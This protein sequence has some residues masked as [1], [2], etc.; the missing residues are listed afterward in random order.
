MAQ[1]A[2]KSIGEHYQQ[3]QA[4]AVSE[5]SQSEIPQETT[6]TLATFLSL[7]IFIFLFVVIFLGVIPLVL[8]RFRDFKRFYIALLLGVVSAALPLTMGL[9]FQKSGLLTQAS[10]EEIPRNVIISDVTF[11]SFSV[12][13][14]TD[15]AV[16][17]VLRYSSDSDDLDNTVLE[18]GGLLRKR[19]HE[20]LVDGLRSDND[21]YFQILSGSRW[22]D[23]SGIPIQVHTP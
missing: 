17:G 7:S 22:Y 9:L 19:Q 2:A 3:I 1:N 10:V 4:L 16:Y 6:T 8:E 23:N 18:V 12:E 14:E 5:E 11:D 20:V 21:Y 15:R 13:W